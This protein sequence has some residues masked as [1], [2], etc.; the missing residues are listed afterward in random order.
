M[1][2]GTILN[3]IGRGMLWLFLKIAEPRVIRVVMCVVYG[4][5]AYLGSLYLI[6]LPHTF[7]GVLGDVIAVVFGAAITGGGIA[8][9]IAILPGW[10]GLERFGI[11]ALW[12][13]LALYLVVATTLGS[14]PIGPAVTI[15]LAGMLGVRWLLEILLRRTD[16][17]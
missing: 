11:I 16:E 17:E 10:W 13:A 2:L 5:F 3:P 7:E 6:D 14:S 1:T 15:C 8:G 9:A 4:T 12:I